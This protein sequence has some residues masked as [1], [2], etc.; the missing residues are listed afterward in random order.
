ME[1]LTAC[2]MYYR[3]FWA[4]IIIMFFPIYKNISENY[5]LY[6]DIFPIGTRIWGGTHR[7]ANPLCSFYFMSAMNNYFQYLEDWAF[8]LKREF[9]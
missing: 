8:L 7:W 2:T 9:Y 5:S 6:I 1:K 4:H 3:P